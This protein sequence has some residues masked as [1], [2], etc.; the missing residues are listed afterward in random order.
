MKKIDLREILKGSVVFYKG[1]I[2]VTPS[3]WLKLRY[4]L[5]TRTFKNVLDF[6]D[7]CNFNIP[8]LL[9]KETKK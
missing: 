2:I 3:L 6:L 5:K 1:D 7:R 4:G 9:K 8:D